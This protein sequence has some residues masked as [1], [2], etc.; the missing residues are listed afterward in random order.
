MR[1][2]GHGGLGGGEEGLLLWGEVSEGPG[3]F[4][5]LVFF[6]GFGLTSAVVSDH[7][8]THTRFECRI[9]SI[10]YVSFFSHASSISFVH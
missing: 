1:G 8:S 2:A 7:Q 3:I 6:L 4:Y 10:L 9:L 5:P